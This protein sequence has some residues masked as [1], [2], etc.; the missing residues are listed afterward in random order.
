M[1][2]VLVS[3][4][5]RGLGLAICQR[6]LEDE[7][8]VVAVGRSENTAFSTLLKTADGRLV[9]EPF[10]FADTG[11]IHA[12]VTQLTQKY[13]SFYGLINNAAIGLDG[14]L[15]TQHERDIEQLLQVNLLAPILLTKYLSRQ[16]LVAR[17]GRIVN[18]SSIIAETGFSGLSV[19]AA[20]KAGLIGF[21]KSLARE[22]GKA[23]IQVN[24]V[25]PGYM[26]TEMTSL[27]Q[28]EKLA[29]ITRRSPLG[30]LA[31]TA[32]VAAAVAYL[33]SPAAASMTGTTITVDAGSTA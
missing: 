10:D 9:F 33:L 25:A 26:S 22:L 18:I 5:T 19:Y 32:D 20:S 17:Q 7:Y 31:E 3:G 1:K 21:T 23:G 13:G 14:V 27:L 8:Q 2:Q 30:R 24:A 11:E 29:S 28:G 15:G 6:L 4:G 12:F 16:M